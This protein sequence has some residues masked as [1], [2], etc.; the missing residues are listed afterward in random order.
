MTLYTHKYAPKNS[1]QVFGQQTGVAALKDFIL[2]YKQKSYRAAVLYGPIGNGKT[3]SVYAVA[4]ELNYDLLEINSSDLRNEESMKTF[5]GSAIGQ[6]SLFFRPKIILI[7]EID[8]ISGVKDR[9]CIPALLKLIE[10]STFPIIV[11]ANDLSDSKFKSL[12]KAC[13]PIEYPAVEHKYMVHTLK[14][15]CEQEQIVAEEKAINALAR[16][17]DGDVRAA[18]IDLQ[19]CSSDKKLTYDRVLTL[20]DRKRTDSILNALTI[21]FKS[22]SAQ[23]ALPALEN[24]DM[25]LRDVIFWLDENLPREYVNPK[26]LARA[27]DY[28]SRADVFQGRIMKRQHWR[29]L[30]YMNDLL[31]AGVSC[32]KEEKNTQPGQ[33]RQTM[34]FLQMWQ[35]KMKIAKKKEIAVKLAAVTHTSDKDAFT[36]V[37]YLQAIFRTSPAEGLIA[38]LGLEEEEVE[39][40]RR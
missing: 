25:E 3:S 28:L 6:Q 5:L 8:N 17:A 37:P 27:Y 15:V 31:T 21:I 29:F 13:Q 14:W 30:A 34:R 40:L 9:G 11:T 19:S 10:K 23:N 22:S 18:L 2:N 36:Q 20:S 1:N 33:Y 24:V 7:D 12:L 16:Q 35:A 26:S 32:A 4:K 38:A 39:W